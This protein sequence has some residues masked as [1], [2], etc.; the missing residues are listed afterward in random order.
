MD[1]EYEPSAEHLGYEA[2]AD[3]KVGRV[4][5]LNDVEG[6]ANRTRDEPQRRE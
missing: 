3:E 1:I 4:M 5:Y 6:P 2:R